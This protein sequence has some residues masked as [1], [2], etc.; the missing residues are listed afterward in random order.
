MNENKINSNNLYSKHKY[1]VEVMFKACF[2]TSLG[3]GIRAR[4]AFGLAT[5]SVV[6]VCCGMI[7]V[8]SFRCADGRL[9]LRRL[10]FSCDCLRRFVAADDDLEK[11]HHSAS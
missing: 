10:R 4:R 1:I 3:L 2:R 9:H 8:G 11:V 7:A 6:P 5:T